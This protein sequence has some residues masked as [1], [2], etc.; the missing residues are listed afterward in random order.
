MYTLSFDYGML[1]TSPAE[2]V[3]DDLDPVAVR[4]QDERKALHAAL[5]WPLLERH[6]AF[7]KPRARRLD[8]VDGDGD[9]PEAAARVCVAR[10]VREVGVRL[11]AVVVREL[12]HACA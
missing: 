9:V 10:R 6:A 8:V 2:A 11:G 4:V 5:V 1:R 7:L 3:T 12:E